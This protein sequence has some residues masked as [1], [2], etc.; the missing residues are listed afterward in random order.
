MTV[1]LTDVATTLLLE[2]PVADS[3]TGRAWAMWI[4]DAYRQIRTRFGARYTDLDTGNVDY[5]VREAV[6]LKVKRPNP[7]TNISISVDDG[8]VSKTYEKGAGQVT[9][10]DDWWDLLTPDELDTGAWTI[11]P[12]AGRGRYR[13]C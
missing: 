13:P 4:E 11:N 6:A 12:V 3:I 5:V 2:P 1:T 7:E 10:I 8:S 9:I